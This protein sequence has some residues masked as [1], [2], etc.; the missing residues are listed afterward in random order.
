M[1]QAMAR[2]TLGLRGRWKTPTG[3]LPTHCSTTSTRAQSCRRIV[4]RAARQAI[5]S[6]SSAAFEPIR[7]ALKH[8]IRDVHA[9]WVNGSDASGAD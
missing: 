7:A 2:G 5:S 1:A 9:P 4:L 8:G 3:K 6:G